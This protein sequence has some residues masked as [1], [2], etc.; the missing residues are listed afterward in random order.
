MVTKYQYFGDLATCKPTVYRHYQ[1]SS[2]LEIP[3]IFK[4]KP[5]KKENLCTDTVADF[6]GHK[7][8]R[9]KEHIYKEFGRYDEKYSQF[10]TE[11][12]SAVVKQDENTEQ[13]IK[14]VRTFY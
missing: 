9:E 2:K 14:R 13:N 1:D 5:K 10:K 3:D 8:C 12:R 6:L 4:E 11:T 7:T